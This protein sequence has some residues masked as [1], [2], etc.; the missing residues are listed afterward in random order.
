MLLAC[1]TALLTLA[2]KWSAMDP[3]RVEGGPTWA[4]AFASACYVTTY[5]ALAC[6]LAEYDLHKSAAAAASFGLGAGLAP[7]FATHFKPPA[8]EI[9]NALLRWW[10]GKLHGVADGAFKI[11]VVAPI[12]VLLTWMGLDGAFWAPTTVAL[13]LLV[14]KTGVALLSPLTRAS[15]RM[16]IGQSVLLTA[17]IGAGAMAVWALLARDFGA[18]FPKVTFRDYRTAVAVAAGILF[19]VR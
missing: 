1:L 5:F 7:S 16:L 4:Q 13:V 8:H 6:V 15:E 10:T 3:L 12:A 14:A 17:V 19:H 11:V 2:S 18:R 9:P